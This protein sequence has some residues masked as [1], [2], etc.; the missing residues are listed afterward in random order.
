M[1]TDHVSVRWAGQRQMVAWDAAGH[2]IV[3]DAPAQYGGQSTGARP[4]EVFLE[5]LGACTAMDVVAVLE[6]KRQHFTDLEVL[7]TATQREDE[8]PK[9]Y[10]RIALEYVVTGYG[11]KPAAVARAVELSQEK[12]CSVRGMLGPA[13]TIVTSFRVEEALAPNVDQETPAT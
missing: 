12:Y 7:V 9:I 2:G 10:N 4:L 1:S 13:V 11:V 3:M 8:F 5:A 6:K